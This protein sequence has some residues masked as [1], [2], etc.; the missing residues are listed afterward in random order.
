MRKRASYRSVQ[1]SNCMLPAARVEEPCAGTGRIVSS[2]L[3]ARKIYTLRS[4][5][6]GLQV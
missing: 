3:K 5:G 4:K 6:A 2:A 1:A